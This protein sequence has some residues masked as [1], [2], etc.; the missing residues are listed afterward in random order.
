MCLHNFVHQTL[1]HLGTSRRL[2]VK[3]NEHRLALFIRRAGTGALVAV[4]VSSEA[5]VADVI[6]AA[7]LPQTSSLSFRDLSL[8]PSNNL[9]DSGIGAEAVLNEIIP[10]ARFNS[11]PSQENKNIEFQTD[12]KI[13]FIDSKLAFATVIT[14]GQSIKFEITECSVYS[15]VFFG[16][17]K[18]GY[19]FSGSNTI[20]KG[21]FRVQPNH[22]FEVAVNSDGE[23]VTH[24]TITMNGVR[25]DDVQANGVRLNEDN[26]WEFFVAFQYGPISGN[27]K[28]H[29]ITL[30]G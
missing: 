15:T 27:A 19:D 3:D 22:I 6:A 1:K 13:K 28:S 17:H 8:D 9:A 29:V 12:H 4:E 10:H 25:L 14:D 11:A 30:K 20:E 7:G 18:C 26:Q 21:L 2:H 5:T 24:L 23:R 16:I